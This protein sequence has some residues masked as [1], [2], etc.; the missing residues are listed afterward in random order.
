MIWRSRAALGELRRNASYIRVESNKYL[1]IILYTN[2]IWNEPIG[3]IYNKTKY[4]IFIFYKLLKF[5]T[6]DTLRM[7]YY[8]FFH[9][10]ISYG[11][12][13]WG[14]AYSTSKSLLDSLQKRLLKIININKFTGDKN[15]MSIDQIFSYESLSYHYEELQSAFINSNSNTRNKSIQILRRY[16]NISIK[17][18]HIRTIIQFNNLPNELKKIRKKHSKKIDCHRNKIPHSQLQLLIL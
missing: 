16:L 13:A 8:A 4:L 18:S 3:Y 2:I 9:S 11:I 12:I 10:I 7:V 17:N 15:P 5:M 14:G 6:T 1:G